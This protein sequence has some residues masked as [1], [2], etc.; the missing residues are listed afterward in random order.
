MNNQEKKKK[1]EYKSEVKGDIA[2]WLLILVSYITEELFSLRK[3]TS[4]LQ[5]N[6]LPTSGK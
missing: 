6:R 2:D 5:G 1:R 3:A 4:L